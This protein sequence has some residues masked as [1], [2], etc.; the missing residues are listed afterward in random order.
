MR[1]LAGS[2]DEGLDSGDWCLRDY[3]RRA[4]SRGYRTCVTPRPELFCGVETVF[5]SDER[6]QEQA[7]ASRTAYLERWGIGRHYCIY[8]G[9]ETDA[10][11]LSDAVDTI[12]G[13]A[14]QGHRFTLLLHRRQAAEFRRRG[15]N[16]LHTGIEIRRLSPLLPQRDLGR[17]LTSLRA[18][19]PEILPVRW[20]HVV[21]PGMDTALP[22]AEMAAAVT[23]DR[24]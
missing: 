14:R 6:R 5:G 22:F 17:T 4:W 8:F 16:A 24:R 10:D 23:G 13:G 20:Q 3:V 9:A 21:P 18:A 15:W 12:L 1:M 7:R 11:S 19:V 2:F